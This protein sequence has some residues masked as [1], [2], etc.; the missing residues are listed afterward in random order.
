MEAST[1]QPPLASLVEG[2]SPEQEEQARRFLQHLHLNSSWT[3]NREIQEFLASLDLAVVNMVPEHLLKR[4]RV[5]PMEASGETGEILKLAMSDPGDVVAIDD[6]QLI[7]GLKIVP[8]AVGAELISAALDRFFTQ[9][10]LQE[11]TDSVGMEIS[12]FDFEPLSYDDDIPLDRLREMVDEAPVVRVVNLILSQAIQDKASHIHIDPQQYSTLVRFRIDGELTVVMKMPHHLQGPVISRLKVMSNVEIWKKDAF[13]SGRVDLTHDGTLYELRVNFARNPAG[14]KAVIKV[15]QR[16]SP[17]VSYAELG[18][19]RQTATRLGQLLERP[20][21]LL[22]VTGPSGSGV[23][24][25]VGLC[26]NRLNSD[27]SHVLYY[28]DDSEVEVGHLA[29][30]INVV[31]GYRK[32][33]Q[34]GTE[35]LNSL[36]QLDPDVIGLPKLDSSKAQSLLAYSAASGLAISAMDLP[37][38]FAVIP[39]LIEMGVSPVLLA[40]GLSG[41]VTQRLARQL[42]SNCKQMRPAPDSETDSPQGWTGR[43]C[44]ECRLRGYKGRTGI[45]EV[46]IITPRLRDII[47]GGASPLEIRQ[48]ALDEDYWSLEQDAAQRA[49]EGQISWDEYRRLTG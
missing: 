35:L 40:E 31:H 47:A 4:Y 44:D 34:T 18:M 26:L 33:G 43:G 13:S 3:H 46:L 32:A 15:L 38:P 41:V 24:T 7:T 10:A 45:H 36:R 27:K 39:R 49:E 28:Q 17:A 22:L 8:H 21:G 9:A 1:P 25:L 16:S 5:M 6:I 29:P 14:E 30:G 20:R 23:S 19:S 12:A 2:L 42:C 37:H 48:A 11:V